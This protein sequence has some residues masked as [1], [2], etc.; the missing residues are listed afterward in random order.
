MR[1]FLAILSSWAVSPGAD[2]AAGRNLAGI[3]CGQAGGGLELR[4]G[5]IMGGTAANIIEFP[6]AVSL[7][8]AHGIHYCGGSLVNLK[9][10]PKIAKNHRRFGIVYTVRP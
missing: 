5:R 3:P 10:S 8:N 6:Y 2:A 4:Q 1:A 9:K 7:Q